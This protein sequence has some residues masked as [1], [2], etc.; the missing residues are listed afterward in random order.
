MS[1]RLLLFTQSCL[2]WAGG[3]LICVGATYAAVDP[4]LFDGRMT[5]L[6]SADSPEA[7]GSEGASGEI[8]RSA[9]EGAGQASSESR[10]FS[11][12]AS[13][14]A[15]DTVGG[16]SSKTSAPS[17]SPRGSRDF[18]AVGQVGRGESVDN[19]SSKSSASTP[20]GGSGGSMPI[21]GAT[22]G[23]SAGGAGDTPTERSF[24]DF[25][26]GATGG[27]NSTVEVHESKSAS[28]PPPSSSTGGA[29]P[30]PTSP[31]ASG[32]GAGGSTPATGTGSGD[33]GSNLPSGL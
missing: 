22:G 5:P 10:D 17:E 15:G 3:L 14:T 23:G 9:G 1:R 11:Q 30:P 18:G 7:S 12:I 32:L 24:E 13:V 16:D 28:V 33:Y 4:D 27:A 21:D 19:A 25:G 20:S 26:F 8:E 31:P 2:A 6:A 29:V